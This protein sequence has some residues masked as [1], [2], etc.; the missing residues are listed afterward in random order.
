MT[1]GSHTW[2]YTI[3]WRSWQVGKLD[4][5]GIQKANGRCVRPW[6]HDEGGD[7]RRVHHKTTWAR[8]WQRSHKIT[9]YLHTISPTNKPSQTSYP[10]RSLRAS[11]ISFGWIVTRFAWIA[12]RFVSS[13]SLQVKVVHNKQKDQEHSNCLNAEPLAYSPDYVSFSCFLNSHHRRRLESESAI[14]SLSDFANQTLKS[15][16]TRQRPISLWTWD[17]VC[18][19]VTNVTLTE[20]FESKVPLT[21]GSIGFHEG[22]LC[23]P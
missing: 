14:D 1:I 17:S 21:F 13:K 7:T 12:A 16:H 20:V 23:P 4:N 22:L 5:Y 11:W 10:P 2:F 15:K 3:R 6:V 19:S 18:I 8:Y 9:R